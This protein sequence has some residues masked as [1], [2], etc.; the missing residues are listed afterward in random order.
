MNVSTAETI[1]MIGQ[2]AVVAA[3]IWLLVTFVL[4]TIAAVRGSKRASRWAPQFVRVAAVSLAG[5]VVSAKAVHATAMPEQTSPESDDR[6][7]SLS[8]TDTAL[9]G[10]VATNV[11]LGSYLVAKKRSELRKMTYGSASI[12]DVTSG[13]NF[14]QRDTYRPHSRSDS[15]N[16]QVIVR[17]LGPPSAEDRDGRRVTFSKGKALELLVWMAEHRGSS[18]RSAARTALWDGDVRD[19]TFANVVSEVRRGL[20]SAVGEPPDD[21][22][23]P[24][25]FS[26]RL[27]L[28]DGVVTDAQLLAVELDRFESGDKQESQAG[29]VSCLDRVTNLPFSGV[30][31]AWAD[32]EGITTS[33]VILVV[34]AAVHLAE[35]AIGNGDTTL[36]F[37]S[38]ERGLRVLP[39]HEEL[40][41]LRMR[42][43]A[44]L[45]NRAAI[46][47]EWESYSRAVES[48]AWAGGEP[49]EALRAAAEELARV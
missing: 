25:T 27:P 26:D 6:E 46:R 30:N 9:L 37:S 10:S 18:L 29:L 31:Y 45:G 34:R 22:W 40:V 42:G 11:A 39:G 48:D 2:I 41:L 33:H 19:A 16:W 32:A 20:N 44:Q 13:Q 14:E 7:S 5:L 4:Q 47:L 17:V 28:H 24:R 8:L 23:L 21:E 49:S 12:D 36:L 1:E 15:G 35:L 43:H 38:T 3:V